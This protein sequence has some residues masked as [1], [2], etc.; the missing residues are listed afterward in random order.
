MT[1]DLHGLYP[2]DVATP[3]FNAIKEA[4]EAGDDAVELIHGHGFNRKGHIRAFVN[5]NTGELGR[6]VRAYLRFNKNLR[7]FMLA[8]FDCSDRGATTVRIRRRS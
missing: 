4:Y 3:V 6:A 8:K 2:N 7:P 1:V 5:S